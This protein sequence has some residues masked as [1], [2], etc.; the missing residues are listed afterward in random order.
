M[1]FKTIL[2]FFFFFFLDGLKYYRYWKLDVDKVCG[3]GAA[4]WDKAVHDASEEY[5]CRPVRVLRI[6]K[7]ILTDYISNNHFLSHQSTIFA[8]ITAIPMLLWH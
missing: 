3:S 2:H 4:T 5:K 1:I 8:L 7:H 6:D